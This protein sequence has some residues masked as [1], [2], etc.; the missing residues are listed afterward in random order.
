MNFKLQKS[1]E[2]LK[3]TPAAY[4]ALFYQMPLDWTNANEGANTWSAFDIIG[5]L[6]HG[7]KTDWIPRAK[8]IL[9]DASDKTFVPFDRFAQEKVSIGKTIEELIDELTLLRKQNVEELESW[10][11]TEEDLS[12]TGIH[13]DP[14]LGM[15]TL[16]QLIATWTIHDIIHLN[17][18]SRVMVKHYRQDVG[19]WTNYIKMFGHE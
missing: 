11:L 7:E 14:D 12:K 2:L 9:S 15:V 5:H 16:K 3:R 6:I 17:Q 8:I 4:K 10:K 18:V 13:P 1:I 19:P